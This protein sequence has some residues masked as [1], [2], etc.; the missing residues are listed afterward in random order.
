MAKKKQKK[1]YVVWEGRDPGVYVNWEKCKESIHDYPKAKYKSFPTLQMA[2]E[3]F[4]QKY[5]DYKGKNFFKESKSISKKKIVGNFIK[6]AIAVDA[7]CSGNPGK[8]EYRGV[9]IYTGK[10]IF[11][12]GPFENSTNNVGEFLALVHALAMMQKSGDKRPIYS[13]SKIAISWVKARTCRT[14]LKRNQYNA[15]SFALVDRAVAW[16]KKNSIHNQ[17]LKWETEA[18]GEIP[19][20]FGRK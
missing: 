18:W 3:A 9:D 16:L 19:A 1:F 12:Q 17:L 13:D 11:R 6:D 8:M 10:E 2:E 4:E 14:K 15:D 7:A 20:D 5:E